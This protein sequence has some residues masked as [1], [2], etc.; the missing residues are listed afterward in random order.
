MRAHEDE[1]SRRPKNAAH[2]GK[3][4]TQIIEVCVRQHRNHRI[5][6]RVLERQVGSVG[7]DELCV[8]ALCGCE[9]VPRDV[10]ADHSPASR[11]QT[12]DGEPSPA[13]EI[14]AAVPVSLAE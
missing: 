2:F 7:A 12:W 10:D 9:L 4:G 11:E 1:R 6:R 8:E 3:D 5:E 13:T 14:E